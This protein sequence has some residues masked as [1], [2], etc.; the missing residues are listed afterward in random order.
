[1]TREETLTDA[2]PSERSEV[3]AKYDRQIEADNIINQINTMSF[4]DEERTRA[5]QDVNMVNVC[6]Y[7]EDCGYR[8]DYVYA[9]LFEGVLPDKVRRKINMLMSKPNDTELVNNRLIEIA[10]ERLTYLRKRYGV[11]EGAA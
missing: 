8:K 4:S 3:A 6:D 7:V 11:K 9:R 2:P 5:N 1:M 10:N